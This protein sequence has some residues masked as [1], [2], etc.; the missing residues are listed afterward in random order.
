M[1][2]VRKTSTGR[3]GVYKVDAKKPSK[4][5]DSLEDAERY[6]NQKNLRLGKQTINT[7]SSK[8]GKGTA[9]FL[10]IFFIIIVLCGVGLYLGRD[11]IFALYSTPISEY[12]SSQGIFSSDHHGE[13]GDSIID[14]DLQFHFLQLGNKYTGDSTYIKAGNIDI[15][16]DAGSRNVS[17]STIANY[18]NKYV[19]DGKLEYVIA[20][21]AHQDHIAGFVG[22]N[23]SLG[24]FKLYQIDTLIDFGVTR[25]T[26]QV[27]NNYVKLRNQLI[28]KGTTYYTQKDCYNS[29]NGAKDI[30]QL[31]DTITMQILKNDYGD[32]SSKTSNEN[33]FSVCTLFTQKDNHY[34]MT[35]DLEEDG[36]ELLIKNNNLPKVQLF[37]AGHHGSYTATSKAL[38]EVIQPQIVT[39]CCCAGSDEYTKI[40]N[41]MFPSQDFI[42]RVSVW[43]ERIYVTTVVSDNE[44]GFEAM[45]G[46]IIISS[47]GSKMNVY[48]SNNTTIL[49]D[50]D[51]FKEHRVWPN[52]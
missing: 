41:N 5:F 34:L 37:K 29:Q 30:F 11:Y 6:C 2:Q 23:S 1:F 38:L 33:N 7:V 47:D 27:Y 22:T 51:W 42:N 8:K 25:T 26:S 19:A 35:G 3:Y 18:L 15:L 12:N 39:V 17:A 28:E 43:T 44:Q 16:I 21:H 4:S 10:S 49:K 32:D 40:E 14:G 20:T 36:E 46:D 13:V 45:N 9:V 50:T 48:G 31:T 24:I 52:S